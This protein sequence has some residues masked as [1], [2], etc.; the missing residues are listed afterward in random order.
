MD[1]RND[2]PQGGWVS[3]AAASLQPTIDR[4]LEGNPRPRVL[5]AGGGGRTHIQLPRGSH[6]VGLD[7]S[8]SQ[9]ERNPGEVASSLPIGGV[10][11]EGGTVGCENAHTR[12]L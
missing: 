12:P 5:E 3:V 7:T 1:G 10:R 11:M 4:L 8:L 6:V 2:G 9:L